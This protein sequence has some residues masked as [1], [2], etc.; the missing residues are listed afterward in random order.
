MQSI[1]LNNSENFYY[2]HKEFIKRLEIIF[3][4]ID[5]LQ[6]GKTTPDVKSSSQSQHHGESSVTNIP[7]DVEN[8][9]IDKTPSG[10]SSIINGTGSTSKEPSIGTN[11]TPVSL[12]NP[13][14]TLLVTDSWR[15]ANK[16]LLVAEISAPL[17]QES[18]SDSV[19]TDPEE[20]PLPAETQCAPIT[21][22]STDTLVAC[23]SSRD[24]H[25]DKRSPFAVL[26]HKKIQLPPTPSQLSKDPIDFS[27]FSTILLKLMLLIDRFSFD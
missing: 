11:T 8:E 21:P 17:S 18:S 4:R 3:N 9:M 26:R 15:L 24:D 22:S 6:V 16:G 25:S 14:S 27:H 20:A 2:H 1:S 5:I 12:T 7:H 13:S 19:F 23:V 10:M